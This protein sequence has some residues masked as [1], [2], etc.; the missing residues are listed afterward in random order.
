M[1]FDQPN[2]LDIA[3]AQTLKIKRKEMGW[4]MNRLAKKMGVPHSYIGKIESGE[5]K[6]SIGALESYCL[7]L[8]TS[9][10]QVIRLSK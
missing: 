9:L 4:V 10:E 5:K 2:N 8:N 1:N 7:A 3:I 6:L